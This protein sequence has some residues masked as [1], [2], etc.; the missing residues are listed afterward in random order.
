MRSAFAFAALSGLAVAAPKPQVIN[1]DAAIDLP[2][3]SV[4]GPDVTQPSVTPAAYNPAVAASSAAVAITTDPVAVDKRD[5]LVSR[6][7]IC[8]LQSGG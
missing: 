1:V 6:G 7:S 5:G 8:P 3:P 2:L 4:L